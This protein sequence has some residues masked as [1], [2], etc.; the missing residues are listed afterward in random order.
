MPF[1]SSLPWCFT[2]VVWFRT[3][4]NLPAECV[5]A[6]MSVHIIPLAA[7]RY[8]ENCWIWV[9]DHDIEPGANNQQITVYAGRGLLVEG[10]QGPLWLVGSS[11]EHRQ[12]YEYQFVD[13]TNVYM[14]Q[15]QTETACYQPN[16]DASVPFAS[17]QY[18]GDRF[19]SL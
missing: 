1:C 3:A 8:I 14:N 10:S 13:A 18:E 19:R 9:A 15:I 11:V 6:F 5:A 12:M 7:S 2:L 16:S 4:A 17:L